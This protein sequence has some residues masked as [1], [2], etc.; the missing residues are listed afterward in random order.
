VKGDNFYDGDSAVTA[1]G[2]LTRTPGSAFGAAGGRARSRP[3][4]RALAGALPGSVLRRAFLGVSG[5][6]GGGPAWRDRG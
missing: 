1:S 4:P 3:P 5:Q 6:F 2:P